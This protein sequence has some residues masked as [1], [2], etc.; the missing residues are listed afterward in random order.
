L[1]W[2]IAALIT[3]ALPQPSLADV[4]EIWIESLEG[5]TEGAQ[6]DSLEF[7][8]VAHQIDRLPIYYTWD[9][10]DGSETI[11][12]IG[13]NGISH[14]YLASGEFTLTLTVTDPNSGT[15]TDTLSITITGGGLRSCR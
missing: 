3:L 4:P 10:G 11:G 14:T 5:N 12:A 15:D 7:F 9:F 6:G 13:L 1:Q 8:A 2:T